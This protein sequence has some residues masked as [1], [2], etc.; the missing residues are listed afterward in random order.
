[1]KKGHTQVQW[2]NGKKK[3]VRKKKKEHVLC[4]T[5]KNV[6]NPPKSLPA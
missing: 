1:M 4:I 3:E 2:S 6:V 5:E